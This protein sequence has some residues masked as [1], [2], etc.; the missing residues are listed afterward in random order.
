ML[1]DREE[2]ISLLEQLGKVTSGD[3]FV[4]EL[5]QRL[6]ATKAGSIDV[7]GLLH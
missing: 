3:R 7:R 2:A 5:T 6:A 4:T 1:G